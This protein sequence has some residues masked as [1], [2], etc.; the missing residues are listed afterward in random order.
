MACN[1]LPGKENRAPPSSADLEQKTENITLNSLE[2]GSSDQS[3]GGGR[4]SHVQTAGNPP[5]PQQPCM[6]TLFSF[7]L[8]KNVFF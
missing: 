5:T 1:Q 2:N 8:D 3:N 6:L 7:I 4:P